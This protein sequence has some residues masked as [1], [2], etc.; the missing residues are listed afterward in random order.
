MLFKEVMKPLGHRAKLAD[1]GPWMQAWRVTACPEF[2][3]HALLPDLPR[4]GQTVLQD[5]ANMGLAAPAT[6][7]FPPR[8]RTPQVPES[9]N[10]CRVVYRGPEELLFKGPSGSKT[11]GDWGPHR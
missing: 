3:F 6:M 2:W 8:M 1:V 11:A 9:P 4:F 7:P 10:K 5:L